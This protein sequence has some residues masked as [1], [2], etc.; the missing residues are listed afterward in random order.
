MDLKKTVTEA[1]EDGTEYYVT[2]G[3]FELDGNRVVAVAP[4][5]EHQS[6]G[7]LVT[8]T[9]KSLLQSS[10]PAFLVRIY[11]DDEVQEEQEINNVAEAE[12]WLSSRS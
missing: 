9:I 7:G 4:K 6:T 2:E 1:L 8:D 10:D 5:P 12:E 3:E 11:E